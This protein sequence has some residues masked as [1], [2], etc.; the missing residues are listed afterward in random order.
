MEK[1]LCGDLRCRPP[2]VIRAQQPAAPGC[3]TYSA[4]NELYAASRAAG[5]GIIGRALLS[6]DPATLNWAEPS[7]HR[8][9]RP[10]PD[11]LLGGL[12]PLGG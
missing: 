11:P 12:F 1:R 3:L 9:R 10:A 6:K 8:V 4:E 2:K 5:S 7:P